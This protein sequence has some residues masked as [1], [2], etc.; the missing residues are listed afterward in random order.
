MTKKSTINFSKYPGLNNIALYASIIAVLG[1]GTLVTAHYM[2]RKK[3]R[4]EI[5]R[6]NNEINKNKTAQNTYIATAPEF[7]KNKE[8]KRTVDSLE[9]RNIELL[10]GAQEKYFARIDRRYTLGRFFTPNQ[11]AKLNNI[12]MPYAN[13]IKKDDS[14]WYMFIKNNTPLKSRTTIPTMEDIIRT[15]DIPPEKFAPMD[16]VID[17]GYL[18]MFNDARQQKLFEAYLTD[19][20]AA[21]ANKDENEPNFAIREIAPIQSEYTHNKR[22]IGKSKR[23]IEGNDFLIAQTL[24]HFNRINDSL[25]ALVEKNKQKLK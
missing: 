25:N 10:L 8:L 11:I 7:I 13:K 19:I 4:R 18:Y 5:E 22:E 21:F 12:V 1:L 15:L 2:G 6:L 14:Q 24:A 23:D 20:D 9:K 17:G 3:A 16:M